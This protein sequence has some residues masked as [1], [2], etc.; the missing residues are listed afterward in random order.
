MTHPF[1]TA[2]FRLAEAE[3]ELGALLHESSDT[4]AFLKAADRAG[5]RIES[6]N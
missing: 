3:G 1:A 4:D 6:I 5:Y 2:N